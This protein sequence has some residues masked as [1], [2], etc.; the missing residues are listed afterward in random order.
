MSSGSGTPRNRT[1]GFQMG[2]SPRATIR[3][4]ASLTHGSTTSSDRTCLLSCCRASH[5]AARARRAAGVSRLTIPPEPRRGFPRVTSNLSPRF[6]R[7]HDIPP[8]G[9]AICQYFRD[10][11]ESFHRVSQKTF[12]CL[13]MP[14]GSDLTIQ[15]RRHIRVPI[16]P[17]TPVGSGCDDR[18]HGLRGKV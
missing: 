18:L 7:V 4:L 12:R 14:V 15:P 10:R 5:R 13:L 3:S 17:H 8:N 2:P 9:P 1:S 6:K 11:C 16:D